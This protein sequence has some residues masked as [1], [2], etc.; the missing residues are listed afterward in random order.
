MRLERLNSLEEYVLNKGT[1]S[2]EDFLQHRLMGGQ[3]AII[4]EVRMKTNS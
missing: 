1:V 4:D 3:L 2:L